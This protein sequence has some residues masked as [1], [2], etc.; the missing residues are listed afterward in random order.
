MQL[1]Y[2]RFMLMGFKVACYVL[3][4]TDI[5]KKW[6]TF[7]QI[8]NRS[9]FQSESGQRSRYSDSLRAGRSG[10]RIPVEA[11]LSA[12]VQTGPGSH[13]ASYTMATGSL[14]RG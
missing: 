2:I 9:I 1:D 11:R 8:K 14:S 6:N 7:R 4:P 5:K 12:P 10:D 3:D 13:A